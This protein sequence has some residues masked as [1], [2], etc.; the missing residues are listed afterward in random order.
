MV[1]FAWAG[2]SG[3]G[4]VKVYFCRG[5]GSGV[6]GGRGRSGGAQ[7]RDVGVGGARFCGRAP[8]S[9]G[10][11]GKGRSDGVGGFTVNMRG[12]LWGIWDFLTSCGVGL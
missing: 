6:G 7:R 4:D 12:V 5:Q 9:G 3:V 10:G 1:H 11:G 2:N 8:V